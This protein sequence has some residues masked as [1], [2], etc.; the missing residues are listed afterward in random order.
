MSER[1][2]ELASPKQTVL[3]KVNGLGKDFPNPF[4]AGSLPKTIKQSNDPP[5]ASLD[6]KSTTGGC[7][8]LRCRLISWQGKKQTVVAN[9]TT[10][11]KYVAASSYSK[12]A[13]SEVFEQ[14]V[15][16]LNAH[17]IKYAL[18]I[19]P[20]IHTSCIEH[21][22]ATVK[23]KTI[24]GELQLQ[25]LV[26]GKKIIIT[27]SIVRTDIQ[28]EDAEATNQKFN[29]SKYIFE[30]MV[31]NLDNVGKFLMYPRPKRK[32][33]EV[34]QP[35]DPTTNVADEAVNEEMDDS[36]VRAA[37]TASSLEA[38]QDNVAQTRSQ[39]VSKLSNDLLLARGNT[40]RSGE[41]SLKLQELMALCTTLPTSV[42]NLET[43]KT[44]Q[45][46]EI[47][48]LKTRVKKLEQK[49]MSKTHRLEILYKVGSSRRVESSDEEGLGEEDASKQRRIADIDANKDIYLGNVHTNEDMFGVNDLDG[50][51]VI[52]DN[53][54]VVKTA[55]ETRSVVKEVTA[56]IEKDKLVSVAE[57]TVNVA[58][59]TISTASTIPVS[60]ATT[61][62]TTTTTVSDVEITLAQ[63]LAELKSAASTRPKVKG[64]VIH[65]QEQAPTP[66]VSSQQPS[67]VKV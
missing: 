24:H 6:M 55:E 28:L 61:T 16:F 40:L 34:P 35:S 27:E 56:V 54:D 36:L 49:K 43:T 33:T 59:T 14:I 7:Q 12:P 51:E 67:Q 29:F 60:A 26:D 20:T 19:N 41:D 4:M 58:A 45:A 50:D 13:E 3:S 48:S 46:N 8:F 32:D 21:F 2:Q 57:V 39:N 47:T 66:T 1:L 9:S 17:T 52:V 30:S 44:T 23:A 31:K 53:V 37:T 22:W 62:T 63:A 10:E 65:E 11:A 38:K 25:A 18:T 42:L 64:F 15:D 5:G